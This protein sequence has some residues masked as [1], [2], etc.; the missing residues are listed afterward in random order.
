MT[1]GR[2]Q[3]EGN[4]RK[5]RRRLRSDQNTVLRCPKAKYSK[6][7]Q[8]F[9]QG[10]ANIEYIFLVFLICS[11]S[12]VW[13]CWVIYLLLAAHCPLTSLPR[14]CW[15]LSKICQANL[16]KNNFAWFFPC[17]FFFLLLS[18]NAICTI[19][20][21]P[22]HWIAETPCFAFVEW[23]GLLHVGEPQCGETVCLPLPCAG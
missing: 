13:K 15:T 11:Q 3:E 8:S 19:L 6:I 18:W 2:N 5:T 12:L 22:S 1:M 20:L 4:K 16:R 21:T 9:C 10:C 7:Q 23:W 14:D 17:F